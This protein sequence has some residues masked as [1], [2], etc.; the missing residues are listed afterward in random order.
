VGTI[1]AIY[2][3]MRI[4]VWGINYTPEV[5]GIAPYNKALCDFI[6][7]FRASGQEHEVEMVT[8]FP[9]YPEWKKRPEDAGTLYRTDLVDGVRV[10]RCWHYVPSRLTA[11]KRIL[12]EGSFV[13]SSLLRICFL[14]RPDVFIGISPPLLLGVGAWLAG[15]IKRAPFVFHVQDLQPDAALGLGMLKQGWFT[16]LLYRLEAFA[17]A[18]ADRVSG[19][20][21]GMLEMF[22]RKAVPASKVVHF[23]NGVT[24]PD[25]EQ[26]PKKGVFRAAH[27]ISPETF[28]YVYSGNLGAKQGLETVVEAA[29]IL[30]ARERPAGAGRPLK[31]VIC[32][33][34][35]RREQLDKLIRQYALRNVLL[36]ALKPEAS[37]FEMLTDM[38]CCLLPQQAGTGSF[39]FPSKLLSALAMAKPVLAIADE[40]SALIQE[41]V[42]PGG[43]GVWVP[44]A[45]PEALAAIMETLPADP[46]RL[47][48]M[49]AAGRRF[50]DQFEITNV[51]AAFAQE[52]AS[53]DSEVPP[54]SPEAGS[55]RVWK[56]NPGSQPDVAVVRTVA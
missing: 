38:E 12:H 29:R 27:G 45:Q 28:L 21:E 37:Y 39:F 47:K 23:P 44:P 17:Y 25:P 35:A 53:F 15:L 16:R 32:G 33:D 56:E 6:N 14:P 55:A 30:Q 43:F 46:A 41:A 24:L 34:G 49:G 3:E 5:T 48:Q 18:K 36:F 2:A 22:R 31:I 11:L 19:I 9:Y 26:P 10:H 40:A 51:L 50:V 8:S 52:L 1:A 42:R 4:I 20:S 54:E 13:L 7:T